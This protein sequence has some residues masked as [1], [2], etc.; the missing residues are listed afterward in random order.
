[1]QAERA[2]LRTERLANHYRELLPDGDAEYE[3]EASVLRAACGNELEE[4]TNYTNEYMRAIADVALRNRNNA[5]DSARSEP[6]P[7]P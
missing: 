6:I 3:D 2:K 7:R 1:M 4:G 5:G